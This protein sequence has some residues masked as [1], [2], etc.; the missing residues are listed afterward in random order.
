MTQEELAERVEVERNTVSRWELGHHEPRAG[1]LRRVCSA[2]GVEISDLVPVASEDVDRRRFLHVAGIG[3]AGLMSLDPAW[4]QA[5]LERLEFSVGRQRIDEESVRDIETI[6]QKH[7]QLYFRLGSLEMLELVQGHVRTTL[8]LQRGTVPDDLRPRL[9][10]VVTEEA[11]RAAWHA[12]DLGRTAT[13]ESFY[14][15]AEEAAHEAAPAEGANVKAYKSIVRVA[16]GR[17]REALALVEDAQEHGV[18][19][20]PSMRAWIAAMEALA[21]AAAQDRSRAEGAFRRAETQLNEA[22]RLPGNRLFW[23]DP[24]R[25]AA[26]AG[27]MYERL[28]DAREA[29][30]RMQPALDYLPQRSP[31]GQSEMLLDLAGIALLRGDA[32]DAV[33]RA[34]DSL[35]RARDAQSVASEDRVRQFRMRLHPLGDLPGIATLDREL[36][37]V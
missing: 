27:A 2:L 31:R 29:E 5:D 23:L 24:W 14:A 34:R 32:D 10:A 25:L 4:S 9:A 21:A 8:M 3:L 36:I 28:G 33:Q 15:V 17:I 12:Y 6:A 11:G 7:A 26:L 22:A 20:D 18:A 1:E 37:A 19:A 13:S 30:R 16:G 35:A